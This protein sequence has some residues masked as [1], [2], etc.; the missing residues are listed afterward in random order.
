MKH[1]WF[2]FVS[3]IA[4]RLLGTGRISTDLFSL[5]IEAQW[6]FIFRI[7]FCAQILPR[8][9]ESR[10]YVSRNQSSVPKLINRF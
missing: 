8:S 9:G 2:T 3:Q 6:D 10:E 5:R 1:G 7:I 4:L